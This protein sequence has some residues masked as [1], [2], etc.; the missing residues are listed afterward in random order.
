MTV[1]RS[2]TPMSW[3]GTGLKKTK[4]KEE[5]ATKRA[6]VTGAEVASIMTP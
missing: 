6:N 3:F 2:S 5:K 4:T 1:R